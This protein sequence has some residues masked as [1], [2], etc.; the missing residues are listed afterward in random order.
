MVGERMK[1][2]IV[3]LE[4]HRRA[5]GRLVADSSFP[6]W[7]VAMGHAHELGL[8]LPIEDAD[9]AAPAAD[10][11]SLRQGDLLLPL[12]SCRG[13]LRAY[14]NVPRLLWQLVRLRRF[15][16]VV[17]CRAP[18]HLNLV[19]LPALWLL[20]F[21]PVMWFVSDRHGIE[22]ASESRLAR[23]ARK[24][25][26]R[27]LSRSTGA[28]E[29]FFA[30]RWPAIV[31]GSHL[32][33]D[34]LAAGADPRRLLRVVS[35]TLPTHALP[36][37]PPGIVSRREVNLLYVGRIAAE[38]GLGDLT[39]A[40]SLLMQDTRHDYRLTVIG[41]SSQGEL[42]RIQMRLREH[43]IEDRVIFRGP[44]PAG[45]PLFAA[46]RACDIFVLPSWVEGTPRVLVEAMAMGCPI[47][48]T[49]VGGVPDLIEHDQHGQL[50][51]PRRPDQLAQAICGL[52][53]D[54]LRRTR[55]SRYNWEAGKRLTVERLAQ[56]MS[57]FISLH[58]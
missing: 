58:A 54:L 12:R 27:L 22:A 16:K 17:V 15:T 47:V 26:G 45:P 25:L 40:L 29:R 57:Q 50:V 9:P 49:R 20:R 43:G 23:S 52:A 48:A 36:I 13:F 19:V 3:R 10:G 6:A 31:N 18:E 24:Q 41:W 8:I 30:R 5:E 21:K 7:L 56:R 4:S 34:L 1:L 53:A 46:F 44:V 2:G 11:F 14:A 55:M 33:G 51:D 37:Q 42:A 38:K 28:A 35:T 39:D 32:E